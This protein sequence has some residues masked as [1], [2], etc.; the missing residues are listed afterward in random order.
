[1]R[2]LVVEDDPDLGEILR[3]GLA[4]DGW[5]ADLS[6]DGEDGLWRAT[7]VEYDAVLLDVM[8]PRLGGIELLRRMRRQGRRAPV[9]LLTARDAVADRVAGL[10]AGADDYVVKPFDWDELLARLRAL[11]RRGPRGGPPEVLAEG[12]VLDPAARTASLRG[13]SVRLTSKEFDL[14]LVLARE[15]HRVFSRTELL[16][17]VWNDEHDVASNSVDVLLSRV[18]RKLAARG[19]GPWLPAVRGTGYALV[20]D[21]AA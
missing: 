11:V 8:L 13:A 21:G 14:L 5:A 6:A 3:A 17:R 15:P 19:G 20:R 16:E 7:T 18:R 12:L 9:L 4:E 2:V 1:M 10:D